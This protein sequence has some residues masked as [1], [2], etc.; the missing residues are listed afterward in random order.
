[1]E[2]LEHLGWWREYS[3]LCAWSS[4]PVISGLRILCLKKWEWFLLQ[5]PETLSLLIY[6][7][8]RK[9][10][11]LKSKRAADGTAEIV[12]LWPSPVSDRGGRIF[13]VVKGQITTGLYLL[14]GGSTSGEM[15]FRKRRV[16]ILCQN[17]VP[18]SQ[19]LSSL[20]GHLTNVR[21]GKWSELLQSKPE[22]VKLP[23]GKLR[24]MGS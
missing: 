2:N 21:F 18:G 16:W 14:F 23:Y 4:N 24:L 20:R 19:G 6:S 7:W 1:M 15:T 13:I 22:I 3:K 10:D 9:E 5:R 8:W 11:L 17:A 12:C